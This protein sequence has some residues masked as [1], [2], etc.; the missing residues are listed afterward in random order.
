M[1]T[2]RG[3]SIVRSH[4]N[5]ALAR[6]LSVCTV[7]ASTSAGAFALPEG[8]RGLFDAPYVSMPV[9]ASLT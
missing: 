6:K 5:R 4:R 2:S 1:K 8:D 3:A 9:L 7:L